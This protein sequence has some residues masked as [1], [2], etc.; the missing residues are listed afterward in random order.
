[1]LSVSGHDVFATEESETWVIEG[2][3]NQW[4][5]TIEINN[6]S[7][8]IQGTHKKGT[9]TMNYRTVYYLMSLSDYDINKP[10]NKT[11]TQ[12]VPV[13]KQDDRSQSNQVVV[14]YTIDREAFLS[15]MVSLGV[16]SAQIKANGGS[17]K[18]YLNNV[19]EVYNPQTDAVYVKGGKKYTDICGYQE[20]L[21]APREIY[22]TEWSSQTK[23]IL[24]SYYN[25]PF[26][27]YPPLFNV[28]IVAVDKD[29]HNRVLKVL[30]TGDSG[31][32]KEKYPLNSS[33]TAP[34]EITYEG[35]KYKAGNSWFVKYIRRTDGKNVTTDKN[36]G[37]RTIKG[38]ILPDAKKN[39]TVTIYMEYEKDAAE[40]ELIIKAIDRDNNIIN[41]NLYTGKVAAGEIFKQSVPLELKKGEVKYSKTVDYYYTYTKKGRSKEEAPVNLASS[42]AS[43]PISFKIPE[44][45]KDKSKLTV[46]IFYDKIVSGE[47][48][49]TVKAVDKATGAEIKTI[50]STK[51]AAGQ[52]YE[53]AIESSTQSGT[54]TYNYTGEWNWSYTLNSSSK[55]IMSTNGTGDKISFNVP[56]A[57]KV[58][59]G[60]TVTV[61]Y[62]NADI[63]ANTIILRTIM[64]SGSGGLISELSTETVTR[65]QLISKTAAA[66]KSING[67]VYKYQNKWEYTYTTSSDDIT[68][69]G[70]GS[71]IS[72]K[73]PDSTKLG[74]VVTL[75]L[76][77]E[78]VQD[79]EV[80]E[81]AAAISLSLDSPENPYGVI[82]AD[83]YSSPYFDSRKGIPTTESQYVYV[84]TKDYLL[85][86]RLVNKTGKVTYTVPVTMNYTLTY[87]SKTPDEY[88]GPKQVT[89][90]E[91]YTQYVQVERAY[92]Y[93]EIERLEYY[94]IGQANIYNYSLPN[95]GVT[96]YTDFSYL[97]LPTLTT[98]HSNMLEDHVLPPDE[99]KNGIVLYAEPIVTDSS[100][101]PI[102]EYE[103][104]TAYAVNMTGEAK[105]R[106]DLLVFDGVAV[107][108]NELKEKITNAPNPAPLRQST[109]IIHDKTLYTE[110]KVVEATKRNGVYS[111]NGNVIYYLHSHSVNSH[112]FRLTFSIDVN[113][114]II[115]TPVI[116]D[117]VVS[118]DNDKWVQLINPDMNAVQIV[119]DPDTT[120]NDFTVRISNTLHHSDRPGYYTRDFSR[121]FIDPVNVSYIAKKDGT[122]R[123][124]VRFPFNV[125]VDI[126]EDKDAS[127]DRFVKAGTWFVLGRNTYRFY[128]PLWVKEGVYTVQFRTVA[129]NGE[130]KLNNTE[131]TRNS[132]LYNYVAISS[133]KFQISGRIY[134]LTLYDISDYPN[135]ENVFR[136]ENTMLIKYFKGAVDG[137]K[138]TNYNKDYA[139]YYTVG[140]NDRYGK[141]TGRYSKFTLPLVNG[142]HPQYKNL[143]VLK[144]GY[145]VRFMLDT[146]GE[147]YGSACHIKITPT[148]YYVD[149]QGRNRRQVDL[150]YNEEIDGKLY[151]LCKVGEGMDLVNIKSGTT[152]NI[153]SRIPEKEIQNTAD[154]LGVSYSKVA[155]QKST[156]YSYSIIKLLSPFRTFIGWDYAAYISSLPSFGDVRAA[157]GETK[158]SLSKYI[159]RWYG[160]YKL[161]VDVYAV[162]SGYD[163]YGYMQKYGIDFSEKF[164]LKDGYIIVN[165]NIVT[166]DKEGKEHLSYINASNYLN[167][168]H[169]S[170]WVTEGPSVEKT[171]SKG[172]TFNFKAGDFIIYYTDKKY[173]DDYQGKLY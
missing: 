170:M 55:P 60:I 10:Y 53:R 119:L 164:W 116:C 95:V 24:K 140:T 99:V 125:Y 66:Q 148:F 166:V 21:N 146:I 168:G 163:V 16:T 97:D 113:D 83:K 173:T 75:R 57:D 144:T 22:G 87:N 43:D 29:D 156:M 45:I 26:I 112:S 65:N 118:A 71:N 90:I 105:V 81:A 153:Y 2:T 161:P 20:I 35:V 133:M 1:M 32:Y 13:D 165:F 49:L 135:W 4:Q 64:V 139:Y 17:I 106:N 102:I 107:L 12:K 149:A 42:K 6:K 152:G 91:P 100:D 169:C 33:Y 70:T 94:Y 74:T 104:L 14:T 28:E 58:S 103:D 3:K 92:S 131:T 50:I 78:I 150:Y 62:S 82:N 120:L 154:V 37:G 167:N 9:N 73:I 108:S 86:Y 40:A 7:I 39:T 38:Y 25:F 132:S 109:N 69:S 72:F 8:I 160:T 46:Y 127:N 31:M 122:V 19:F 44:D 63:D 77:Y 15:A 114:V 129:V 141:A 123:N 88:G 151:R 98:W 54:K 51:V 157:T 34:E 41:D 111:S 162:E 124:E 52:L 143:G 61:Y 84:K 158:L 142:S 85:G 23:E 159:Q 18:V 56:S 155:N 115:H 171:D 96:L 101:K 117:P 67:T 110:G 36:P 147:M 137:T 30:R 126:L 89:V 5:E 172:V 134:G 121:S 145:A 11:N 138:K 47:I 48:P 128:V 130:D 80:P 68:R 136:I 93:W 27:V 76:Y 59:G 79:I